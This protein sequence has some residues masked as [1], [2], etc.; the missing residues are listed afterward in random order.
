MILSQTQTGRT[1]RDVSHCALI[2]LLLSIGNISL[3]IFFNWLSGKPLCETI[4]CLN[5]FYHDAAV[6]ATWQSAYI[7]GR[8]SQRQKWTEQQN[9]TVRRW[10]LILN[11]FTKLLSKSNIFTYWNTSAEDSHTRDT[12][13]PTPV[14]MG[15]SSYLLSL[16]RPLETLCQYSFDLQCP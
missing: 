13:C 14:N 5:R 2:S 4:F 9:P 11:A 15:F 1:Q 3:D 12:G 16:H 6:W 10:I 7:S 8:W